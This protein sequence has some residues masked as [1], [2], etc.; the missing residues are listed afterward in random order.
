MYKNN[1]IGENTKLIHNSNLMKLFMFLQFA[2]ERRKVHTRIEGSEKVKSEMLL[3]SVTMSK[4]N[5]NKLMIYPSVL[6]M[7]FLKAEV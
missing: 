6:I 4:S 3:R 1:N 5:S 2:K 7:G